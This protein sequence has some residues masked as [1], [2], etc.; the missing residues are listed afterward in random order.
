MGSGLWL[1]APSPFTITFVGEVPQGTLTTAVPNGF[2]IVSS[3]VPQSGGITTALGFPGKDNDACYK[4]IPGPGGHFE[5]SSY[6]DGF[7]WDP[8]EPILSVGEAV[9]ILSS[10][11]HA[12]WTRV[13]SVN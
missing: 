11:A 6:I 13:F 5:I 2:S 10:G 8:A 4:Y 9:W 1:L 7:G 3:Q 12:N